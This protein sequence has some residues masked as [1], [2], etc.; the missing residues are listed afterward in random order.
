MNE[1][2]IEGILFTPK[3]GGMDINIVGG[4]Y[5]SFLGSFYSDDYEAQAIGTDS[6]SNKVEIRADY[7]KRLVKNSSRVHHGES[8]GYAREYCACHETTER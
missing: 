7:E 5:I 8:K 6:S 2:K 1:G 4:N 3:T